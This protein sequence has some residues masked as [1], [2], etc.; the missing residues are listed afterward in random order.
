MRF[1]MPAQA[2]SAGGGAYLHKQNTLNQ[3]QIQEFHLEEHLAK[4]EPVGSGDYFAPGGPRAEP[5]KFK[6]DI[7]RKVKWPHLACCQQLSYISSTMVSALLFSVYLHRNWKT[8]S[9]GKQG[10]LSSVQVVGL[11]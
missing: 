9:T 6:A 11:P 10:R 8:R 4:R 7:Q 5:S 1:R 3:G 2:W